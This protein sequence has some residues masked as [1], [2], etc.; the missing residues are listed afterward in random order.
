MFRNK[1]YLA[2]VVLV[3]AGGLM[4]SVRTQNAHVGQPV[5]SLVTYPVAKEV[6]YSM[7]NDSFPERIA[8]CPVQSDAGRRLSLRTGV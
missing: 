4:F 7:H 5:Q 3:L 8:Y 2:A 1:Y 6:L